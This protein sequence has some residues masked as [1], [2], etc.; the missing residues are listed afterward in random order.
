MG[1][2][3]PTCRWTTIFLFY[4]TLF[5]TIANSHCRLTL[6]VRFLLQNT[7][8]TAAAIAV[9]SMYGAIV[10]YN[11]IQTH[12]C[13]P[14]H[15]VV[16]LHTDNDTSSPL[17]FKVI[18]VRLVEEENY[19]TPNYRD[20]E[21]ETD[22]V[23]APEESFSFLKIPSNRAVSMGELLSDVVKLENGCLIHTPSERPTFFFSQSFYCTIA[24]VAMGLLLHFLM[25]GVP[26]WFA[27][28][29]QIEQD[30]ETS[31]A[32]KYLDDCE[33]SISTVVAWAYCLAVMFPLFLMAGMG[34]YVRRLIAT[35]AGGEQHYS[36]LATPTEEED[37]RSAKLSRAGDAG[38]AVV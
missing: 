34:I 14:K 36:R 15:Q 37:D 27:S 4:G 17:Y 5:L 38:A 20:D 18:K 12:A 3:T 31:L 30:A 10:V 26:I 21:E 1:A 22:G 35:H 33:C 19:S 25:K 2:I 6:V 32:C 16:V 23:L 24:S 8:L 9:C 7:M 28:S 11:R 29:A 13:M